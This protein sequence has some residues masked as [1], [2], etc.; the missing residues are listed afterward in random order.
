MKWFRKFMIG[1]YGVVDE[2]SKLIFG[3][4]IILTIFTMFFNSTI[5]RL[6]ATIFPIIFMYR[7]LSKD[8][9]KRYGENGRFLRS[10][11]S[12]KSKV[13]NKTK[14]IK[15]LKDYK[16]FNCV[17]CDQSL[18]VPR[19]KGRISITCPKCKTTMIKKS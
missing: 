7:T 6:L 1:R 2:L 4:G 18:R 11:N 15:G 14:R 13:R 16:Y 17:K 9:R 5:L 19:G 10:W 12:A 3:I 8:V